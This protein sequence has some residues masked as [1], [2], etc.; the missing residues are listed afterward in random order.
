[1][2]SEHASPAMAAP[3]MKPPRCSWS[4][5]E[6]E[7]EDACTVV[8]ARGASETSGNARSG[9][10]L[11]R[12]RVL[13]HREAFNGGFERAVAS[14]SSVAADACLL[15][16]LTAKASAHCE[17]T[18]PLP[19][20]AAVR[21]ISIVSSAKTVELYAIH[22][23]LKERQYVRTIRGTPT[24]S[25]ACANAVGGE[26]ASRAGFVGERRAAGTRIDD[27]DD[28]ANDSTRK[29]IRLDDDDDDALTARR[30]PPGSSSV[31]HTPGG[32]RVARILRRG[33]DGGGEKGRV[34]FECAASVGPSECTALLVKLFPTHPEDAAGRRVLFKGV[35][36]ELRGEGNRDARD[37]DGDARDAATTM[38]SSEGVPAGLAEMLRAAMG[39]G[40]ARD[41]DVVATPTA[42]GT[43]GNTGPAPPPPLMAMLKMASVARDAEIA[44]A[45]AKSLENLAAIRDRFEAAE[46]LDASDEELVEDGVELAVVRRLRR[47]ETAVHALEDG[48]SA[49]FQKLN[50]RL[51][52]ADG[53]VEA[54]LHQQRML[55]AR[56]MDALKCATTDG[57][58]ADATPTPGRAI[59]GGGEGKKVAHTRR[60]WDAYSKKAAPPRLTPGGQGVKDR[61]RDVGVSGGEEGYY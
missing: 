27:D 43:R 15:E 37:C 11:R 41:L 1:M 51:D 36:L 2:R 6:A 28:V 4:V 5:A 38:P 39:G 3:R 52:R 49:M 14:V 23:T 56:E 34:F 42:A 18:I 48:I 45:A 12:V 54:A 58:R 59:V 9:P 13:T 61:E 25:A 35:V 19:S 21:T 44:D 55:H 46:D 22:P 17:V 20:S 60:E 57:R 50:A 26:Y 7:T 8:D 24:S 53:R 30:K 16:R 40:S 31:G 10:L 32:T 47:V 33:G 29:Q